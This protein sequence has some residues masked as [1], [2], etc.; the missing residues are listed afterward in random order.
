MTGKELILQLKAKLNHLDTASNRVVRPEMALLFLND[1]Y[2]KLARAKYSRTYEQDDTHFQG[3]QL[4]SD[5]LNHLT[6]VFAGSVEDLD[7][8]YV[9]NTLQIAD[10]WV[11]TRLEVRVSSG[12]ATKWTGKLNYRTLD[13]ISP[14][15]EDP[16]NKPSY[17]EILVYEAQNSIRI[18]KGDFT[19]SDFKVTYLAKPALIVQ[20]EEVPA[21]F[22]D[23]I[24]DLAVL[25]M[26]EGWESPRVQSKLGIDQASS[27]N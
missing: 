21:P 2:I 17:N 25:A 4:I 15:L 6:K 24:V 9:V 18:P 26:L 5:D 3:N 7:S 11:R 22:E 16:F 13:K 14:A 12:N 27:N 8:E 20:E 10:Y 19:I 23:E 1:S